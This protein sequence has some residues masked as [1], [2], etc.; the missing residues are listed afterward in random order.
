MFRGFLFF[1]IACL[2][3]SARGFG[4]A[5]SPASCGDFFSSMNLMAYDP[6]IA[7]KICAELADGKSLRT[8]CK[9]VDMP[10][11]ATVFR[12]LRDNTDFA[13]M[14]ALAHDDQTD[15]YMDEIVEIADTCGPTKAEI[16]QARLKIYAR[17]LYCA[18]LRPKKYGVKLAQEITGAD[19]GPVKHEH[20]HGLSDQTAALLDELRAGPG[21]GGES[22][23]VQD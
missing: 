20:T 5:F 9:Q 3:I 13:K 10:S 18:K 2:G 14:Y 16:Q 12:W 17:E 7:A 11:K 4:S 22:P 21:S 8:I 15:G 1:G 19:G 23:P 6:D